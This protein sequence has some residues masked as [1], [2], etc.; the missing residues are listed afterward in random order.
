MARIRTPFGVI[1]TEGP[2]FSRPNAGGQ[3]FSVDQT[4]PDSGDYQRTRRGGPQTYEGGDERIRPES[5]RPIYEGATDS[6]IYPSFRTNPALSDVGNQPEPQEETPRNVSTGTS[7]TRGRAALRSMRPGGR[8]VSDP[9]DTGA[10]VSS[11]RIGLGYTNPVTG[12]EVGALDVAGMVT[13]GPLGYAMSAVNPMRDI[14]GLKGVVGGPVSPQV[15]TPAFDAT[16]AAGRRDSA[17][18]NNASADTQFGKDMSAEEAVAAAQEAVGM[19]GDNGGFGQDSTPDTGYG[20]GSMSPSEAV[21]DAQAAVGQ[22]GGGG[23]ESGSANSSPDTG[24]GGGSMSAAEG[25]SAAQGAVGMGG[26]NGGGGNDGGGQ[27]ASGGNG[28]SSGASGSSGSDSGSSGG[29]GGVGGATG[30]GSPGSGT[31]GGEGGTGG[32]SGGGGGGGGKIIC[33][34][35]AR[36]G[37]MDGDLRLI[38]LVGTTALCSETQIRGYHAWGMPAVRALRRGHGRRF[39][40]FVCEHRA[41][42]LHYQLSRRDLLPARFKPR[43]R[44][45]YV[46]KLCRWALEGLSW[47]VGHGCR[48]MHHA[49]DY[50]RL[51]TDEYPEV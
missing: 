46:G 16:V 13:P 21:S 28:G 33:T 48:L 14:T 25:V 50:R 44:P 51:Y 45:D 18:A 10:R 20:G 9:N 3:N 34:E 5:Q 8:D 38:S 43:F 32:G 7:Q 29:V 27:G 11:G 36:Q 40:R 41:H 12:T 47:G 39:W 30:H 37:A 19:S 22:S 17:Q 23:N 2:I 15:G 26:G 35:L 1:D 6:F 4:G 31:A 42:E 49:P 24:F